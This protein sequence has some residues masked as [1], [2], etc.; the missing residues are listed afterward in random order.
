MDPVPQLLPGFLF[1]WWQRQPESEGRPNPYA[2]L[3]PDRATV[4]FHEFPAE[5]EPQSRAFHL[6]VCSTNLPEF[7]EHRPVMFRR[8]PGPGVDHRYLD[9]AF[10][11]YRLHLD[12]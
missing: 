7:L 11:H 8:D 1:I 5:G 2:T 9:C 4:E 3:D 12:A 10:N 6:S